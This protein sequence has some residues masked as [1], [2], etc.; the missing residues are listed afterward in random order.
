[1]TA[2]IILVHLG[3]DYPHY[4][5]DCIHQLR[6]W[7]NSEEL[8][9]YL[10]ADDIHKSAVLLKDAVTFVSTSSLHKSLHHE[11]FLRKYSGDTKFREGYWRFV[12]ERFFYI[13]ELVKARQLKSV[14]YMEY[15]VLFYGKVAPVLEKIA[16]EYSC[17]T[18]EFDQEEKAYPALIYV[19][20]EKELKTLNLFLALLADSGFTDMQLLGL[21]RRAYPD[22]IRG[23]PLIPGDS[24][25]ERFSNTGK[26]STNHPFL[27]DGFGQIKGI[28][29]SL[30]FGQYLGGIDPRN[31]GGQKAVGYENESALYK[32]SEMTF[33]WNRD[34]TGRWFPTADGFPLYT[35]HMH[36]KALRCFLSDRPS[37]PAADYNPIEILMNLKKN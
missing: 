15:D 18:A 29:D 9:I 24:K 12:I 20:N 10:I 6:V 32:F 26:K 19:P 36:S 13:E 22:S 37:Q 27:A 33:A 30:V 11:V 14:F 8:T 21:Y 17:L 28:F 1:M 34:S 25:K 23:L 35:I 16:A 4:L 5:N 3:N 2:S 7:N 31:T